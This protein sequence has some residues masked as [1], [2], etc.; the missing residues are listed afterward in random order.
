M[1]PDD[2]DERF[3]VDESQRQPGGGR[4]SPRQPLQVGETA[5]ETIRTFASLLRHLPTVALVPFTAVFLV[6][7]GIL[8]TGGN[9]FLSQ[10]PAQGVTPLLILAVPVILAAYVAFL[11]DWHRL[12]LFGP[13]AQTV[14]PRLKLHRRDLTYFGRGLLVGFIGMLAAVPVVILAPG[15]VGS[16][17]GAIAM[18]L[19]GGL[20]AISAMMAFGLVLPATAID[21]NY[22][23]GASFE[24]TKEVLFQLVGL[25]VLVLA[26]A[27]V[28]GMSVLA[29]NA[30][31]FGTG[32]GPMI[33]G[34]LI[35]LAVEFLEM[36]LAA[37]LLSVIFMKRAGV[38]TRA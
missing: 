20:I 24:A 18:T 14:R 26:P 36:A 37:T 10:N 7:G 3:E 6:Q 27:H 33:P 23:I 21:R 13:G 12:V 22:S 30:Q 1:R 16:Q 11:V 17:A 32:S 2:G 19:I 4:P 34:V 9:P 38:D 29:L 31:V 5:R 28:I 8:L 35:S 25:V 15:M